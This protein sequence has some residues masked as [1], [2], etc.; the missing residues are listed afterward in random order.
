[1]MHTYLDNL[2]MSEDVLDAQFDSACWDVFDK[3]DDDLE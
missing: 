2:D 1:M 3:V